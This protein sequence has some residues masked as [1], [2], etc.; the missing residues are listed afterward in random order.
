MNKKPD[1]ALLPSGYKVDSGLGTVYCILPNDG[2]LDFQLDRDTGGTRYSK[3]GLIE[4]FANDLPR[5]GWLDSDCPYLI[6][7]PQA[8]NRQIKSEELD[9]AVWQKV[10]ITVTADQVTSPDGRFTSDKI[11]RTS[12]S[13][14]YIGDNCAKTSS[15]AFD[16]TTSVFVK[17]GKG[18]FFAIR[19]QG[20]YP[21]RAEA[22][23]QFSNQTLTT[24]VGGSDF[25]IIRS[26]VE[27]YGDGWY[28][29][30]F[31]YN[32]DSHTDLTNFFSPRAT[33]GVIDATDTTSDSFAYVWG[34]QWEQ[35]Q[36]GATNYIKNETTGAVTKNLDNLETKSGQ[37]YTTGD[38]VT[39]YI[40]FD[41]YTYA[42]DFD[43]MT[44]IRNSAFDQSFD[45]F[46]YLSGGIYYLRSR[47]FVNGGS[48]ND[49]LLA[50]GENFIRMF[51]KNK[52]A[53]R[54]NLN[55]YEIYVNGSQVKTGTASSGNFDMCNNTLLNDFGSNIDAPSTRFFDFRV[56]NQTMTSTELKNLTL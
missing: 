52:V 22:I 7:E 1:L 53:F 29:L 13:A 47:A 11:L 5:I 24:S 18:D 14:S 44:V 23:F 12:T 19:A 36:V 39:F 42:A 40:E 48:T 21:N 35:S 15:T 4:T 6:R 32:T 54:F 49:D 37:T 27:N 20:N 43:P 51:Q 16:S 10:N 28:R 25:T 38:D 8:V 46:T 30:Q 50:F 9:N 56:Y 33:S 2:T 26:K 34:A 55:T 45:I 41:A 31:S 17:K 3:D